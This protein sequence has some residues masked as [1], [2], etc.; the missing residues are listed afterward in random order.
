MSDFFEVVSSYFDNNKIRLVKNFL[1]TNNNYL[2]KL[3]QNLDN[4]SQLG[5]ILNKLMVNLNTEDNNENIVDVDNDSQNNLK[6]LI[7]EDS[8][9][10]DYEQLYHKLSDIKVNIAEIHKYF[11]NH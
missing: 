3:R 7:D 4:D 10:E 11:L 2:D 6:D 1:R 5:M 8:D 9:L